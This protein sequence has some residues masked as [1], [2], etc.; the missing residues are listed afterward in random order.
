MENLSAKSWINELIKKKDSKSKKEFFVEIREDELEFLLEDLSTDKTEEG[1][2]EFH[3]KNHSSDVIRSVL[4]QEFTFHFI[5]KVHRFADCISPGS[6]IVLTERL[7][8]ISGEHRSFEHDDGHVNGELKLAAMYALK[9][10]D[11]QEGI[12]L[13]NGWGEFREKIENKSEIERLKTAAAL[14]VAEIDRLLRIP[15]EA[16]PDISSNE[17]R[18]A[19]IYALKKIHPIELSDKFKKLAFYEGGPNGGK[20]GL[21]WEYCLF[22]AKLS[23]LE[24]AVT[25]FSKK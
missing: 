8:Q 5:R 23:E 12:N 24:E 19:F 15:N 1:K 6:E 10:F 22:E 17:K 2:I 20:G 4:Y 9:P 3:V 16:E 7:R 21:N 13:Y 14:I 11:E 18:I 25:E